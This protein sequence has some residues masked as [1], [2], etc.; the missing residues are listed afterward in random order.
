[1]EF[2][3]TSLLSEVVEAVFL[4]SNLSIGEGRVEI[5]LEASLHD[6][7]D[8]EGL[9]ALPLS[10]DCL[11]HIP[12]LLLGVFLQDIENLGTVEAVLDA[13]FEIDPKISLNRIHPLNEIFFVCYQ[14]LRVRLYLGHH[15]LERLQI[16]LDEHG[17]VWRIRQHVDALEHLGEPTVLELS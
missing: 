12:D 6:V 16:V 1:M 7:V 3:F 11:V 14:R 15:L 4:I 9:E 17:V 8:G 5:D 2:I 13:P 10:D